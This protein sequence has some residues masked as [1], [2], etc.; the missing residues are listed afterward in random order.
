MDD[1]IPYLHGK[2]WSEKSTMK[3]MKSF[4]DNDANSLADLGMA[5]IELAVVSQVGKY[6][7]EGCYI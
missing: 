6:L 4:G 7:V 2:K 3:I 1:I 5:T